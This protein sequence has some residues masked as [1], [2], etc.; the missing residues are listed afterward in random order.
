MKNATKE[1]ITIMK[2]LGW[3]IN[4]TN[5]LFLRKLE[6]MPRRSSKDLDRIFR[7]KGDNENEKTV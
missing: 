3:E 5:L 4:E 2:F 6:K 1:E 7:E